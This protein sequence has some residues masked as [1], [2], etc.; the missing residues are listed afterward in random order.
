M[1]LA[2]VVLVEMPEDE[3]GD[4]ACYDGT[5]TL[6]SPDERRAVQLPASR[7]DFLRV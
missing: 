4:L 2:G 6:E 3:A 7:R 1:K 5:C